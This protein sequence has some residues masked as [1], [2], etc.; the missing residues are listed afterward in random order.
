M[1]KIIHPLAL[2][3]VLSPFSFPIAADKKIREIQ[4][5]LQHQQRENFHPIKITP[6]DLNQKIQTLTQPIQFL[7][8][9][10]NGLK[11][12]VQLSPYGAII[13]AEQLPLNAGMTL[14][15]S[16]GKG[17]SLTADNHLTLTNKKNV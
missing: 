1:K 3:I 2:V 8:N 5:F 10:I 13:Q 17:T 14:T 12:I 7:Q 11:S 9:Q 4:G 15:I 6:A 16:S